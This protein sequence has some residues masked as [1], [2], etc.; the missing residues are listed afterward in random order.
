MTVFKNSSK[1]VFSRIIHSIP[2]LLAMCVMVKFIQTRIESALF[3]HILFAALS[4]VFVLN[5]Y[6]PVQALLTQKL[7]IFSDNLMFCEG[8]VFKTRVNAK[9]C[10]VTS[11]QIDSPWFLRI[12]D[13]VKVTISLRGTSFTPSLEGVTAAKA[14]YL[15]ELLQQKTSGEI[16]QKETVETTHDKAHND[17]IKLSLREQF[18]TFFSNGPFMLSAF[19]IGLGVVSDV[20]DKNSRYFVKYIAYSSVVVYTLLILA[21]AISIVIG[22]FTIYNFRIY[23]NN[24][25]H[26]S[27]N[28]GL[29]SR[30]ERTISRDGIKSLRVSVGLVDAVL[31]TRRFVIGTNDSLNG[32]T[33]KIKFPA[34]STKNTNTLLENSFGIKDAWGKIN[35]FLVSIYI[36]VVAATPIVLIYYTIGT[37][38]LITAFVLS[39]VWLIIVPRI[40]SIISCR[41]ACTEAKLIKITSLRYSY[42]VDYVNPT[43]FSSIFY[44]EIPG[45][46]WGIVY[47]SAY[48]QKTYS[49]LLLM[50]KK[51]FNDLI[52]RLLIKDVM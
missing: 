11:V 36:L 39:L 49:K 52:C 13:L 24:D 5:V 29:L 51:K 43:L 47:V 26:W 38:Y 40:S 12:L 3:Q 8:F 20:Y 45:I 1:I 22:L 17:V 27:I 19:F 4:L 21:A 7:E 42:I 48:T 32:N 34:L 18:A 15:S 16:N 46:Q 35:P 9:L 41:I 33:A 44:Y 50:K 25:N 30:Q 14:K 37:G 31:K 10:N 28:Y 6:S 23:K 2:T